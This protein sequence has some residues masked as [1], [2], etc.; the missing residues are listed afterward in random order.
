MEQESN[1]MD[2]AAKIAFVSGFTFFFLVEIL[3]GL[4]YS[5]LSMRG[6]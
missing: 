6:L 2:R 1:S 4:M 5:K 3:P